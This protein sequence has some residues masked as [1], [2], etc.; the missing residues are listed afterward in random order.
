MKTIVTSPDKYS[1]YN[2][3]GHDYRVFLAGTIDNGTANPWAERVVSSMDVGNADVQFLDPRRTDW[4]N[5]TECTKE[6][7]VFLDQ[8]EWELDGI[9]SANIVIFNFLPESK[10]PVTMMEL[11]YACATK[12][13]RSV[14][15]CCPHGFW[16]KGNV[17]IICER[18]LIKV[19]DAEAELIQAVGDRIKFLKGH[20]VT[21]GRAIFGQ[22]GMVDG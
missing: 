10:S 14:Y 9:K 13:F 5:T 20:V 3:D 11:G 16:R 1:R 22:S 2:L 7:P 8:V 21:I 12:Y 6:N 19:F 17:D 18:H 15:V 4:D